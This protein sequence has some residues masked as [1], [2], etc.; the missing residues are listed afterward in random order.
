MST[1]YRVR[2]Y[3]RVLILTVLCLDTL[4]RQDSRR[5]LESHRECTLHDAFGLEP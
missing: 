1:E 2:S 5:D 4:R 3:G